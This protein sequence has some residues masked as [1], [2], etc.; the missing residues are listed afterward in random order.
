M[1]AESA[2]GD[3]AR[4]AQVDQVLAQVIRANDSMRASARGSPSCRA[5]S[6]NDHY[7]MSRAD[8][9]AAGAV[10]AEPAPAP[11][12]ARRAGGARQPR[13]RR[14]PPRRATPRRARPRG[15]GTRPAFPELAGPAPPRQRQCCARAGSRSCFGPIRRTRTR[16]RR[17][18]T[19]PRRTPRNGTRWRPT[20]YTGSSSSGIPRSPK[21]ATALYKRA[22]MLQVGRPD[23]RGARRAR[24]DRPGISPLGRSGA[25]A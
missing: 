1:R 13:R 15:A 10:R 6:Q 18:S 11:G 24:A 5:T 19:S 7:E 12:A 14:R 25:R 23:R 17:W 21:A 8:P 20:R 3:S 4:R 22:L 16:P 2:R 9:P